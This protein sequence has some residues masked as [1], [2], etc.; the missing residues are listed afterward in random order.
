MK[1]FIYKFSS[2]LV[3]MLTASGTYAVLQAC[4]C[5]YVWAYVCMYGYVFIVFRGPEQRKSQSSVDILKIGTVLY[6]QQWE[7]LLCRLGL[8]V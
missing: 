2:F 5:M 4:M 1:T 8:G 7:R 6:R 3:P